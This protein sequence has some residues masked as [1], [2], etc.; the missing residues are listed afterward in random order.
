MLVDSTVERST[1]TVQCSLWKHRESTE[2]PRRSLRHA[3]RPERG[4][5][6]GVAEG[7]EGRAGVVWGPNIV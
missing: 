7:R 3:L 1:N 2:K 5:A 4:E 6:L